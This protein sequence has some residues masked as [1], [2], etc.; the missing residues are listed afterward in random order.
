M[1]R[2][3]RQKC[4]LNVEN[5]DKMINDEKHCHPTDRRHSQL[6]PNH[7]RCLAV[8]PSN[9]GKTNALFNLLFDINGLRFSNIYLFSKSLF[10]PKYKFLEKEVSRLGNIGYYPF[11]DN[12]DVI[13]PEET[14]PN[15]IM[16]FDD[17][18]TEKQRNITRYFTM[19]RHKNVDVFYLSQ[20]YSKIPKQL[21]RDNAN[22]LLVFRQDELN[23]KHIYADH[24]A[25]DMDYTRFKDI[26]SYAWNSQQKGFLTIDRESDVKHGRYR[27]NFDLFIDPT[28]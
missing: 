3:K 23:M 27:V 11:T 17:V 14:E 15:S 7:I 28:N 2:L 18:I 21:V 5:F 4:R 19:G 26:C 16:I 13:P 9:C 24:V 22:L 6:L 1:I 10:Q 12:D 8:G 25:P 20:T